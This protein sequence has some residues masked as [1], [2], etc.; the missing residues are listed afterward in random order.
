MFLQHRVYYRKTAHMTPTNT[1][2]QLQE[3]HTVIRSTRSACSSSTILHK[4]TQ[5]HAQG[6][7]AQSLQPPCT[8]MDTQALS[9]RQT[10][11]TAACSVR[12]GVL[13]V[14]IRCGNHFRL[15]PLTTAHT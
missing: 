5:T 11:S 6:P 2:S 4:H 15:A 7:Q 1:E 13:L 14:T 12:G 3:L 8:N 10:Q 9:L